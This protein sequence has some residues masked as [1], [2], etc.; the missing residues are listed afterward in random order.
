VKNRMK[1]VALLFVFLTLAVFQEV[2]ASC[3]CSYLYVLNT[4]SMSVSVVNPSTNTVV[5]QIPLPINSGQGFGAIA[6][7]PDGAYVYAAAQS[8]QGGA[9]PNVFIISTLT[10][11]VVNQ[12]NTG[13]L[14]SSIVFTPNGEW[15]YIANEYGNT[16]SVVYAPTQ[17]ISA[18]VSIPAPSSVA[19]S[20]DGE[21]V[22]AVS[23]EDN[24]NP[25]NPDTTGR[26]YAISVATNT[27]SGY[28]QFN[29]N[30]NEV[31]VSTGG[32][33]V[34]VVS[35]SGTLFVIDSATLAITS[36]LSIGENPAFITASPNG[37]FMFLSDIG[38]SQYGGKPA[39]YNVGTIPFKLAA[40]APTSFSPGLSIFYPNSNSAYVLDFFGDSVYRVA[41]SKKS[42]VVGAAISL[43]GGSLQGIAA[44]PF[45]GPCH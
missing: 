44:S 35:A 34:Y 2:K 8:P 42:I 25:A 10:W 37:A 6:V 17:T 19:V 9:G 16:V 32:S 18:A 11:T 1:I 27:V 40:S 43:G 39:L 33:Y 21:T 30:P 20:P 14:V 45:P 36:K 7:S 15:A 29:V 3:G 38:L 23:A 31:A 4:G 5:T 24:G 12:L 22:Y 41:T 26:L 13:G 28:T